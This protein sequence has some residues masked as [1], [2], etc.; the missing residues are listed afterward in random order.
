MKATF[1]AVMALLTLTSAAPAPNGQGFPI[2]PPHRTSSDSAVI[3]P[4]M[5]STYETWPGRVSDGVVSGLVRSSS[6]ASTPVTTYMTFDIPPDA[7]SKKC[8]FNLRLS[9]GATVTGAGRAEAAT[10]LDNL[11]HVGGSWV[12]RLQAVK[13]GV[14]SLAPVDCPAGHKYTVE[15]YQ[16]AEDVEIGW[17]VYADG[18]EIVVS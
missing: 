8:Q 18:P 12:G 13:G 11:N 17:N 7:A 15:L 14:A 5:T 6:G 2:G 10:W 4:M 16:Y 9:D 3:Y 1:A